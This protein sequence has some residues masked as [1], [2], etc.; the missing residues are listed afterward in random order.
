MIYLRLNTETKL[1][2]YLPQNKFPQEIMSPLYRILGG[3]G[4]QNQKYNEPGGFDFVGERVIFTAGKSS[5][6]NW[7]RTQK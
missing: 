7:K 3:S 1:T 5:C 2:L 6:R 4:F